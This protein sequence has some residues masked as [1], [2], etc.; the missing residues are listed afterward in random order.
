MK[1]FFRDQSTNEN[2]RKRKRSINDYKEDTLVEAIE[3]VKAGEFSVYMAHRVYKIP[4]STIQNHV[5]GKSSGFRVG[6]PPLFS[7]EQEK[8]LVDL[9]IQ[10]AEWGHPLE[11]EEFKSTAEHFAK[12]IGISHNGTL[13]SPGDDWLRG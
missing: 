9:V 8:L 13:W 12:T 2:N 4:R 11:R 7:D 6:R 1:K 10:L 3:K 5:D